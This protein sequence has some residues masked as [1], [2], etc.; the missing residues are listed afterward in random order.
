MSMFDSNMKTGEIVSQLR[1]Y[2]MY[3]SDWTK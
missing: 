2:E 3:G 1:M